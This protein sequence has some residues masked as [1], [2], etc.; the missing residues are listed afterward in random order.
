MLAFNDNTP[1]PYQD[2]P[3]DTSSLEFFAAVSKQAGPAQPSILLLGGTDHPS[4]TV[5]QQQSI[6]RLDRRPSDYSHA[7]LVCARGAPTIQAN[8]GAWSSTPCGSLPVGN[9]LSAAALP[10]S[11]S[12]SS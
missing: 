11:G 2:L 10:R 5:R 9:A 12:A 7:V 1:S 8:R 6:L 4:W 3:A